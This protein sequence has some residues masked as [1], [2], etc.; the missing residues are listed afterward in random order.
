[1]RRYAHKHVDSSQKR[2]FH[3]CTYNY[4]HRGTARLSNDRSPPDL[5]ISPRRQVTL[6]VVREEKSVHLCMYGSKNPE[7][8]PGDICETDEKARGCS[9]FEP[10]VNIK[11]AR[12]EFMDKLQDDEYVFNAYRDVATLQWVLG[13]RVH[14]M[15]L[16][17]LDRFFFWF[18]GL[19]HKPDPL[20]PQLPAHLPED[21]WSD[22]P[23]DSPPAPMV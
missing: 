16:S 6:M 19:F 7:D 1:M 10:R 8:W 9:W 13:E 18:K 11:Q 20:V 12:E 3:N 14:T 4:E 23:D 17:F 21:I 2:C 15:G 22:K 5:E